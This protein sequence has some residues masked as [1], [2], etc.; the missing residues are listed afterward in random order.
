MVKSDAGVCYSCRLA[1]EIILS[2]E[3]LSSQKRFGS[4]ILT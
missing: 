3:S 1:I 2:N 4:E